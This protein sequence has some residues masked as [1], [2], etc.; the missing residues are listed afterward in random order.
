MDSTKPAKAT[1][2]KDLIQNFQEA[3]TNPLT[4]R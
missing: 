3:V 4:L 2:Y 1:S